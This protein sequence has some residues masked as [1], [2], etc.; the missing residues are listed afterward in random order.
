MNYLDQTTS[1]ITET[2]GITLSGTNV[3]GISSHPDL[4]GPVDLIIKCDT[5]WLKDSGE[6]G[7]GTMTFSAVRLMYE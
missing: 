2:P 4:C 1:C 5:M 6:I 3:L 7:M